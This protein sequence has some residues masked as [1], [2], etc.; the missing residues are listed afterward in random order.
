GTFRRIAQESS[1]IAPERRARYGRTTGDRF[2]QA[3]ASQGRCPRLARE[4]CPMNDD[5]RLNDDG[6]YLPDRQRRTL[7]TIRQEL[8]REFGESRAREA[9]D[10]TRRI[11]RSA[12]R[13]WL[14]M[15][16]LVAFGV[17]TIAASALVAVTSLIASWYLTSA[18]YDAPHERRLASPGAKWRA[19]PGAR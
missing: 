18:S 10:A 19:T 15:R 2:S 9:S 3:T 8:D 12:L 17:A 1:S 14:W 11:W 6:R 7:D 5:G 13:R 4:D 16:T